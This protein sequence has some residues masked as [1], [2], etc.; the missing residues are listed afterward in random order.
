MQ[1]CLIS[2]ILKLWGLKSYLKDS[3]KYIKTSRRESHLFSGR[4]A[5]KSVLV[6]FPF[7]NNRASAET[8]EWMS[9]QAGMGN[10]V[11]TV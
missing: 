5:K 4:T 2:K 1:S 6:E 11:L 7:F 8:L 3:L 9:K 10:R